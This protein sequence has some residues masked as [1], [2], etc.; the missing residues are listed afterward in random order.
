MPFVGDW[1]PLLLLAALT[2]FFRY[3]LQKRWPKP[4]HWKF[5]FWFALALTV[6]YALMRGLAAF[7]NI[8]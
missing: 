2:L 7:L 1:L 5:L 4:Q 6:G 3:G 8:P